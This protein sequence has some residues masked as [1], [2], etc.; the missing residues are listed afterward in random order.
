MSAAVTVTVLKDNATPAMAELSKFATASSVRAR[1]MTACIDLTK[2]HVAALGPNKQGWPTT[3]FYK[4][5]AEE[6][7]DGLLTSDGFVVRVDHPNKPGSMR[8][9]FYG[10][11]IRMKDKMLTIPARAEFYGR[12]ATE[13]TNLRLAVFGSGTLALVV[14]KGGVGRVNF[15]TGQEKSV[16]G[17]GKR[18]E[19]MVAYWL[20]ESVDQDPDAG[21]IPDEQTY[22]DT[23]VENLAAQFD[24][25]N[26]MKGAKLN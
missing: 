10:G 17:A 16:R 19:S 2:E 18:A 9:R 5:V 4:T 24:M 12:T 8:Q 22:A 1:M 14:G 21:V 6:G 23:C 11:T 25:W 7:T 3:N 26:E 13:F 15:A 20:K